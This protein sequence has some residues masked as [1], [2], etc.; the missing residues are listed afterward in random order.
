MD[1]LVDREFDMV[2]QRLKLLKDSGEELSAQINAARTSDDLKKL[3]DHMQTLSVIVRPGVNP[4][5][6]IA[7]NISSHRETMTKIAA[8]FLREFS[9]RSEQAKE[10][11]CR[12]SKLEQTKRPRLCDNNH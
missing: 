11:L 9:S 12:V 3:M 10:A 2:E 8:D 4:Y 6:T 5:L 1:K 7:A